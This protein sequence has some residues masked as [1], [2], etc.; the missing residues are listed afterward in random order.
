[1]PKCCCDADTANAH[2]TI[3]AS[4]TPSSRL[5]FANGQARFSG[6]VLLQVTIVDPTLVSDGT[7]AVQLTFDCSPQAPTV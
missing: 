5:N 1:M 6:E 3:T 7:K 2:Q 4:S